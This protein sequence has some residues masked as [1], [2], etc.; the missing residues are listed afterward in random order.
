MMMSNSKRKRGRPPSTLK[1]KL[2]NDLRDAERIAGI[3][4]TNILGGIRKIDKHT[5]LYHNE[6][7]LFVLACKEYIYSRKERSE[8]KVFEKM[9]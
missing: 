4:G 1:N 3:N 9:A 2:T 5:L 8:N 6:L 7:C